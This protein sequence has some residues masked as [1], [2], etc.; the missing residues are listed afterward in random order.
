[1]SAEIINFNKRSAVLNA[2]TDELKA[3]WDQWDGDPAT[4]FDPFDMEEVHAELNRRG[5]GRYCAV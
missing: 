1:M 5:E 4:M 2:S 3:A